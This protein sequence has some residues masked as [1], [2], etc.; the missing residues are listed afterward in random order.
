MKKIL[1]VLFLSLSLFSFSQK[2]KFKKGIV[3][4]DGVEF[5]KYNE[6]GFF[7]SYSTLNDVE[8][9][10]VL[11]TSYE[12]RN[13]AY[14]STPN[15]SKFGIKPTITKS[16]YTVKFPKLDKEL[17]TNMFRKDLITAVYK[18]KILNEDGSINEENV[19]TFISK[20]NNENLKLKI[21]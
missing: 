16:V 4:V 20:Y 15:P 14:Y 9:I 21:N 2:L 12:E 5:V 11:S 18:N 7:T 3:T 19:D 13:Q 6:E 1:I 10:T 8:F 17:T